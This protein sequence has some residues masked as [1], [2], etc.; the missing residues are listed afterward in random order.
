MAFE[1]VKARL[2]ADPVAAFPDFSITFILQT[3]ASDYGIGAILIQDT[4][5]SEKVISCS[6]RTLNGAEMNYSTTE[7]ECLRNATRI[8]RGIGNNSFRRVQLDQGHGRKDKDPTAEV[9]GPCYGW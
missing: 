8:K 3:D 7:N 1:E 5:K 6:S 9:P 2:V 4:E